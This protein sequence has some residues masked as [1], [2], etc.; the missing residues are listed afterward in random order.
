MVF[1]IFAILAIAEG[2]AKGQPLYG[3]NK[4]DKY[5]ARLNDGLLPYPAMVYN[6]RKRN[7]VAETKFCYCPGT[8]CCGNPY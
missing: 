8:V 3:Q 4:V 1:L 6:K 5:G 2:D 7:A